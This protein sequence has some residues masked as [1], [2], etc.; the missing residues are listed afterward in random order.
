MRPPHAAIALSLLLVLGGCLGL[1]G[2]PQPPSDDRAVRALDRAHEAVEELDSYRATTDGRVD[3]SANEESLSV[4]FTVEETVNVSAR[5]LLATAEISGE[6]GSPIESGTRT[7]Y[8]A[9]T[10]AYV[11]CA[12]M[13][14]GSHNLSADRPWIAYTSLGQQLALLNRTNVYW[15]GPE[16]VNGTDAV[17]VEAHPSK[18]A[19][20]A[21]PAIQSSSMT[22]FEEGSVDNATIR[23]WLSN[24]TD[25]P[26]QATRDI[27]ISRDGATA[28]A[29][30]TLRFFDF[31]DPANVTRPAFDGTLWELGCPG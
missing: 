6:R 12:R 3:V 1:G 20:Q 30:G 22:D 13:G 15:A 10:R 2:S 16:T 31:G 29:T 5:T 26:L 19:L 24:E 8:L 7:T 25:L 21:G 23:V 17:V 14:W 18:E 27:D 9:D 28:T 11:E 4:D